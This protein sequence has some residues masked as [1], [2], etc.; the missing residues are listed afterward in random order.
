MKPKRQR[1]VF[2]GLGV[3]I[4]AAAVGLML[5]AFESS[6]VFFYGPTE[7]TEKNIPQD[8]RLRIGGLVEDGSVT[9]PSADMLNFRVTDLNTAVPVTY[10]GLPPA[11]FR[12]GQGVVAEGRFEGGVFIADEILAKH[13]ETYMPAEVAETLKA[14]G[15]WRGDTGE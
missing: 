4:I 7:L 2:T 13:D 11:L 8:R 9:R 1:M 14:Q 3:V 5:N 15:V 6:V 12:E 10:R